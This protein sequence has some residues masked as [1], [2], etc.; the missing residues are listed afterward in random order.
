MAT[1][2]IDKYAGF[3]YEIVNPDEFRE[4][5][6]LIEQGDFKDMDD[7]IE[8]LTVAEIRRMK[9]EDREKEK[10]LE[11]KRDVAKRKRAA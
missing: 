10:K 8:K 5:K 3:R 11:L 7:Y 2:K 4:A 9:R 1:K 6:W